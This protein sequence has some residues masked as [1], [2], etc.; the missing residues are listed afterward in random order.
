M[1]A[2]RAGLPAA[3]FDESLWECG[4]WDFLLALTEDCV[5]LELPAIAVYY[6]TD[7]QD[8]LTGAHHGDAQRVREKWAR[9]RAAQDS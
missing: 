6:R 4:D 1:I 9:R 7:G 8:R 3:R 5:P 2:H